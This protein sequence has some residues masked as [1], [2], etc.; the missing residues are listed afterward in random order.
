MST[1]SL[2]PQPPPPPRAPSDQERQ[3][4]DELRR[5][6]LGSE[7]ALADRLRPHLERISPE[8]LSRLLPTAIRLRGT[9][10]EALSDALMPTIGAALKVAVKRDPQAVAD[11]IF[12]VMGPAIRQAVLNQFR[13]L[14]EQLDRR[15]QHGFSWQGLKW[16]I[17]AWQT[18]KSFAEVVLYHTII[19]RVEHVYLIH[20]ETGLL[21]QHVARKHVSEPDAEIES[22]MLT[23]LKMGI[24]NLAQDVYGGSSRDE[25]SSFQTGELTF[26]FA[27]GPQLVLACVFRGAPTEEFYL[28]RMVPT[29]ETIHREYAAEIERFE[30]DPEPFVTTRRYLEDCLEESRREPEPKSSGFRVS[31]YLLVPLAILLLA[32]GLWAFMAIRAN[33]RWRSFIAQLE[34]EP[35]IVITETGRRNW[36]YFVAGLRDPLVGEERIAEL[37]E[38][39]RLSADDVGSRWQLYQAL[40]PEIVSRRVTLLLAP[41]PSVNLRMED[42]VVVASGTAPQSWIENARRVARAVPGVTG[43]R[44]DGLI[45]EEI[46]RIKAEMEAEVPRFVLGT[47]RF[48]PGQDEGRARLIADAR[49]LFALAA[50]NG[51]TV[52]LEVVGHTDDTGTVEFNDR[53]SQERAEMVKALFVAAGLDAARLTATGVGS[54]E[55]VRAEPGA[56]INRSVTFRVTVDA[57]PQSKR[58]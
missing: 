31:P 16:R 43:F 7:R 57:N 33:L 12:P 15:L 48:A 32:L 19:Y 41:P 9:K 2:I 47:A 51:V 38:S 28:E 27:Q 46:L 34:A 49:R 4:I 39:N 3:R 35:G 22:G 29:I 5:L 1:Q 13:Q 26:W 25:K 52:R 21:L 24:E 40:D 45:D 20:K 14:V 17:E 18:R 11:A 44:E 42:G 55:P 37:R 54:R 56:E 50:A 6:L 58:N 53:L 30:G 10:D 8:D 36:R 23:A